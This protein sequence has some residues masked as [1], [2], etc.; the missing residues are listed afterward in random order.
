MAQNKN[1]VV[2]VKSEV[3]GV[4][5]GNVVLPEFN[6][7]NLGEEPRRLKIAVRKAKDQSENLH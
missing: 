2:V 5:S 3:L 4:A 7:I 6:A 1:E